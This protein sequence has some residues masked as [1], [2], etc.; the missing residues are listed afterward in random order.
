MQAK[1]AFHRTVREMPHVHM[2]SMI[3]RSGDMRLAGFLCG[4]W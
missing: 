1:A 2:A 3:S 4:F